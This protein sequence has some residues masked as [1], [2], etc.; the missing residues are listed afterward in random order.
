MKKPYLI[1]A[2][3][4]STLV[5]TLSLNPAKSESTKYSAITETL[6]IGNNSDLGGNEF[7]ISDDEIHLPENVP[8][9]L[10]TRGIRFD[11]SFNSTSEPRELATSSLDSPES[12]VVSDNP[13]SDRNYNA[14]REAQISQTLAQVVTPPVSTPVNPIV[15]DPKNKPAGWSSLSFSSPVSPAAKIIGASPDG[16]ITT[17]S[18]PNDFSTQ[19]LNG[20]NS[21]GDFAT[22]IS[23]D[24]LPY[25]L[26]RGNGFSLAEYRDKNSWLTRFLANTKLSIATTK[27]TDSVGTARLGVGVEFVLINDGDLRR[28]ETFFPELEEIVSKVPPP[29]SDLVALADYNNGIQ[30]S[31]EDAKTKARREAEQQAMWN[32][33]FSS[34][35]VSPTGRYSDLRGEGIGVWSTYRRG[36]GTD[37]QLVFHASYRSNERINDG[38]NNFVNADTLLGGVRLLSGNDKFRFSLETAYNR[39]SQAG[40]RINDYISFG[41]G[42]EPKISDNLWLSVSLL[43]TTGR[44]NGS[45]FQIGTGIK[46][47][48]N[49]G[50]L[51]GP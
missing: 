48:F 9:S 38:N 19:L 39:E 34:G 20:V 42:L 14:V 7:Q 40:N 11:S 8:N 22:G 30:R 24:T 16:K 23:I 10:D 31:I 1:S 50:Y 18:T 47:N 51:T 15:P 6:L 21:D 25:V 17:I 35:W 26:I 49:T 36:I 13:S 29:G 5:S 43:G 46:W 45:D 28:N 33:A 2:L 3:A 32:L 27:A 4:L 41:L 12:V 37:S 44:Q